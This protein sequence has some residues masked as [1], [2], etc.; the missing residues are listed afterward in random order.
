MKTIL[1][2]IGGLLTLL[3]GAARAAT[4]DA[5]QAVGK[6]KAARQD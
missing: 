5:S 1:F 2:A 3:P 4:A 6:I